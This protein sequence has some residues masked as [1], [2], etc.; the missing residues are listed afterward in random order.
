MG[1]G[2]LLFMRLY[3]PRYR[4]WWFVL[5]YLLAV[6]AIDDVWKSLIVVPTILMRSISCIDRC[7]ISLSLVVPNTHVCALYHF[8]LPC[9]ISMLRFKNKA[10]ANGWHVFYKKNL[11][12]CAR[13]SSHLAWC[14]SFC[15]TRKQRWKIIASLVSIPLEIDLD[16][17]G[18]CCDAVIGINRSNHTMLRSRSFFLSACATPLHCT[19]WSMIEPYIA[20]RKSQ[21]KPS[22]A[23]SI[24]ITMWT[25]YDFWHPLQIDIGDCCAHVRLEVSSWIASTRKWERLWEPPCDVVAWTPRAVD[26]STNPVPKNIS[27][28]WKSSVLEIFSIEDCNRCID[29]RICW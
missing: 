9:P 6:A 20:F 3:I 13:S 4:C 14:F 8:R 27:P 22:F 19:C 26:L 28:T 17:S 15:H 21:L 7:I 24:S 29:S 12:P 23:P 10:L 11:S 2:C 1:S 18:D 5:H 16:S 25:Q